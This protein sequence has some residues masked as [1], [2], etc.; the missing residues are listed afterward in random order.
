MI[1]SP[2][3]LTLRVADDAYDGVI[4]IDPRTGDRQV[5]SK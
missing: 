2:R 3:A 4:A 1:S 5:I